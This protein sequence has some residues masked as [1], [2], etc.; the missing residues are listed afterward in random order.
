MRRV[1]A[2]AAAVSLLSLC[3]LGSACGTEQ[4]SD[5]EAQHSASIDA[6]VRSASDTHGGPVAVLVVDNS[7]GEITAE[8][9]A[10]DAARIPL[11]GRA[12]PAASLAKVAV[13]AAALE[14]GVAP[15]EV[16]SVPQCIPLPERTACT[17]NPGEV[18]LVIAVAYSNDPAFIILTER[19]GPGA[20]AAVASRVGMAL[21]P[22]RA[23]PLG[24]D[25]VGMESVAALFAALA[26]DGETLAITRSDGSE[27]VAAAGRLVSAEAADATRK[28]LRAVVTIGTGVA[29]DGDDRPYGKTGTAEGRTD[30]W[31]AGV[32]GERTI[33]VW[34]GAA[35]SEAA[36]GAAAEPTPEGALADYEAWL[37]GESPPEPDESRLIGGGLPAQLFRQVADIFAAP[38]EDR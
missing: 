4:A 17:T 30:A 9:A 3:V 34:V 15:S 2:R 5:R 33:V 14:A 22:S 38:A 13:L 21:E 31:F 18:G 8:A 11:D 20:V 12:R 1:A 27:A 35:D 29:A 37:E 28:L 26:N 25:T 10:G 36:G 6:I 23:L 24:L 32:S 16:L 19:A 7:T